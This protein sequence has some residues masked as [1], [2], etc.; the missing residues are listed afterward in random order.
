MVTGFVLITAP[1]TL[2]YSR[3]IMLY[4]FGF[5][6]YDPSYNSRPDSKPDPLSKPGK[7][8]LPIV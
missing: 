1:L 3:A 5:V 6:H 4:L 2:R 8:T 7:R